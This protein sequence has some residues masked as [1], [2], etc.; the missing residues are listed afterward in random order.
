VAHGRRMADAAV[1][2][3]ECEAADPSRFG[4]GIRRRSED[5]GFVPRLAHGAAGDADPDRIHA[6][7]LEPAE[8]LAARDVAGDDEHAWLASPDPF[9]R[10]CDLDMRAVCRVDAHDAA[11]GFHQ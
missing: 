3:D 5:A 10:L 9:D 4:D 1:A 11:A 2:G 7:V 6:E 8:G